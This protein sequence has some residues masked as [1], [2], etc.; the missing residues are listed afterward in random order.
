MIIFRE[1]I[2][3]VEGTGKAKGIIVMLG[4]FD[5]FSEAF[6]SIARCF[7]DLGYEVIAFEGPGQGAALKQYGLPFT[8]GWERTD[9]VLA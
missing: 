2:H 1:Q 3:F 6:Y 7:A 4:G 8:Y 5:S 9:E